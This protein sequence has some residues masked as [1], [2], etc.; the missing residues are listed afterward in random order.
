ML[1]INYHKTSAKSIKYRNINCDIFLLSRC[2]EL[3]SRDLH[4]YGAVVPICIGR[5]ISLLRSRCADS[6]RGPTPY[7]GV[8][9]PTELQRRNAYNTKRV[10]YNAITLLYY[11]LHVTRF[12]LHELEPTVRFELTTC[13]LQNSCSTTELSRRINLQLI[14]DNK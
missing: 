9:L 5:P 2:P 1:F 14:T 12:A 3:N 6:N 7:H 10:T 4:Y 11:V 13:C 8:A